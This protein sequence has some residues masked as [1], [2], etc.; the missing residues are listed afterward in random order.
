MKDSVIKAVNA[1]LNQFDMEYGPVTDY[2]GS[3]T[4]CYFVSC[5]RQAMYY[6]NSPVYDN[7]YNTVYT[8]SCAVHIGQQTLEIAAKFVE[9]AL[10]QRNCAV[11]EATAYCCD[12]GELEAIGA[13]VERKVD[14]KHCF[15]CGSDG[16]EHNWEAH[17]AEMKAS[18]YDG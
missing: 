13:K 16:S 15:I 5:E 12:C 6:I 1:T 7:R 18:S 3:A 14:S 8:F 11:C 2:N 10:D 9:K 4:S 17:V